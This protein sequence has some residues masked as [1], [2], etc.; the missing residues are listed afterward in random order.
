MQILELKEQEIELIMTI[1]NYK[2]S[3]HNPSRNLYKIAYE[4]I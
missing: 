3:K 1:R 4:F 2:K